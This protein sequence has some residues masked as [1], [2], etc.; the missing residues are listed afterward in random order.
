MLGVV[1]Q[2]LVTTLSSV[3]SKSTKLSPL[4]RALNACLLCCHF[5]RNFAYYSVSRTSTGI[6]K[7]GFWLTV[8]GNFFDICVLEW[9]KLFGNRNGTYHWEKVLNDP[10]SFRQKLLNTHSID[11]AKLRTLWSSVKNYRDDFVAHSEAQNTTCIPSMNVPHLLVFFYYE[12]LLS[13]FPALQK[14]V[15]LPAHIDRYYDRCL[16]EAREAFHVQLTPY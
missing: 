15:A 11:E 6:N 4:N 8:H 2:N 7:E 12:K 1:A 13:D 3:M 14:N 16:K 9:C 10:D 5:T